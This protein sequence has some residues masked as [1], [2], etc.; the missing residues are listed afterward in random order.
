MA[1]ISAK[2][3]DLWP[4]V[5]LNID[6][7]SNVPYMGGLSSTRV[8]GLR[9]TKNG[10]SRVSEKPARSKHLYFGDVYVT[11]KYLD[12]IG[13]IDVF[14]SAWPKE[15]DT[16]LNLVLYHM[17]NKGKDGC[18]ASE[19]NCWSLAR[20]LFP[21]AA[22][23]PE[24]ISVFLGRLG[25]APHFENFIS[26]YIE[27]VSQ[28]AG[29]D[30]KLI[31]DSEG[32][33]NLMKADFASLRSDVAR[34]D[35][36]CFLT[37]FDCASKLPVYFKLGSV[38]A[39][40]LSR[41]SACVSDTGEL[42]LDAGIETPGSVDILKKYDVPFFIRFPV[43]GEAYKELL[44][45]NRRK[46]EKPENLKKINKRVLY[47]ERL[48]PVD[49]DDLTKYVILNRNA[50]AEEEDSFKYEVIKEAVIPPGATEEQIE[51]LKAEIDEHN[52]KVDF[53]YSRL[54]IFVAQSNIDEFEAFMPFAFVRQDCE[55]MLS[56][57][58]PNESSLQTRGRFLISIMVMIAYSSLMEKLED[59]YP[60]LKCLKE[61]DC[62]YTEGDSIY[63]QESSPEVRKIAK[64]LG[65]KLPVES[66]DYSLKELMSRKV[67]I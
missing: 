56:L 47:A 26:A 51:T 28:R 35:E 45:A 32:L 31:A 60:R 11:Y 4:S 50:Q 34:G 40:V 7:S 30:E 25:R 55:H 20:I 22:L 10:T 2:N 53:E 49:S 58:D 48:E 66:G 64:A 54:G 61:L 42:R 23:E 57:F 33:K 14:K 9:L 27:R 39:K 3:L 59:V 13:L 18:N 38:S 29:R 65:I 36:T 37:A 63:L 5:C 12:A 16:V 44:H 62:H 19:W 52:E 1:S 24:D 15:S 8:G 6:V 21:K 43:Y 17:L 46:V 67:K 41:I